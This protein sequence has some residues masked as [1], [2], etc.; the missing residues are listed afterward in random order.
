MFKLSDMLPVRA[1]TGGI[2]VLCEANSAHM[3]KSYFLVEAR[4]SQGYK[5]DG[6]LAP[7]GTPETSFAASDRAPLLQFRIC[8]TCMV[9]YLGYINTEVSKISG[10]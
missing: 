4:G 5:E 1:I 7:S 10:R 3:S 9:E 8:P 2:E 6:V